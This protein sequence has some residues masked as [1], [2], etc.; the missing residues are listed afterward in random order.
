[1]AKASRSV[2]VGALHVWPLVL[3]FLF[4]Y[5]LSF[6][7]ATGTEEEVRYRDPCRAMALSRRQPVSISINPQWK[8]TE[9][10]ERTALQPPV[11]REGS[12]PPRYTYPEDAVP[13]PQQIADGSA[14][15]A[16]QRAQMKKARRRAADEAC[17]KAYL[18]ACAYNRKHDAEITRQER[19]GKHITLDI[20]K[21]RGSYRD[22]DKV[23]LSFPIC[24]GK[25]STPTPTGHFHIMEKDK[26]HRSNLHNGA[27][28][29]Y[30]LRLTL[31]GVGL[32]EGP[33][34]QRPSSHGCIRL[35]RKT[36]QRLFEEC[37]VGTPV[38]IHG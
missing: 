36:A 29:P 8:L 30:F 31:D 37:P 24:S 21:Q 12:N 17:W 27:S 6:L 7:P 32:H 34:R 2:K 9:A 18:D 4:L 19:K 11:L 1:M 14:L 35:Y 10:Q 25:R 28:M 26:N 38:F 22:G 13:T 16:T 33:V 20:K 15:S 5:W 3:A 23:L